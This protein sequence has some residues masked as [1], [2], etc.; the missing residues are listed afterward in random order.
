MSVTTA[1]YQAAP[2]LV[3]Y[4]GRYAQSTINAS[5][6]ALCIASYV[7]QVDL[8]F[9]SSTGVGFTSSAVPTIADGYSLQKL[10]V[11]NGSPNSITLQDQGTLAN[12]N[13]RLTSTIVT[14]PVNSWITMTFFVGDWWQTTPVLPDLLL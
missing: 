4:S 5:S 3:R 14:L 1:I 2:P 10:S 9:I 11:F 6:D 13:L 12:S 8:L 7:P